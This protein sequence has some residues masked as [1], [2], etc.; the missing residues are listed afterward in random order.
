MIWI[1]FQFTAL[2]KRSFLHDQNDINILPD[3]ENNIPSAL[4]AGGALNM[5]KTVQW[6][7]EQDSEEVK[8][9]RV[10]K[11]EKKRAKLV[12]SGMSL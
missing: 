5:K 10:A 7:G 1:E 6:K 12:Y 9:K 11:F 3:E 2:K 4:R 8:K